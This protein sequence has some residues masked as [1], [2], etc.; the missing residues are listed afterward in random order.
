MDK[1]INS[2][3]SLVIANPVECCYENRITYILRYLYFGIDP[4]T[5]AIH[6]TF[7]DISMLADCLYP[8]PISPHIAHLLLRTISTVF[9]LEKLNLCTAPSRRSCTFRIV[10][11]GGA[12]PVDGFGQLNSEFMRLAAYSPACL[13]DAIHSCSCVEFSIYCC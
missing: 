8:L 13:P 12:L 3:S 5:N 2:T 6:S 10:I 7:S 4:N 11:D 1:L 9:C